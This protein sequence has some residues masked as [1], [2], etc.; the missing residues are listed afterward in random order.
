[1]IQHLAGSDCY[2]SPFLLA[3]YGISNNFK[4][5]DILNRWL[6]IFENSRQSNVRIIAFATDCDPRYL[7]AMHLV[8]GFFEKVHNISIHDHDKH[9]KSSYGKA[10]SLGF[11]CE[12]GRSFSISKIQRTYAQDSAIVF[13]PRE[14]RYFVEKRLLLLKY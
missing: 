3:A 10:G 2:L 14:L 7:L 9:S 13:S 11:S 6:W 4:G 5:V 1:M 8:T 12:L